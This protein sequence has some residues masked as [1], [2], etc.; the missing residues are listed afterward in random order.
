MPGGD[1]IEWLGF[2][3][4]D[5]LVL[6]LDQALCLAVMI[7]RGLDGNQPGMAARFLASG[8]DLARDLDQVVMDALV[9][10]ALGQSVDDVAGGDMVT[11][12]RHQHRGRTG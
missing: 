12:L 4:G 8:T 10:K 5:G 6:Q 9:C 2:C 1:R 3:S 11:Q 7:E